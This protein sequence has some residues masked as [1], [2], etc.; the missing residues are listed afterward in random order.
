MPRQASIQLTGATER[1]VEDKAEVA[2]SA[3]IGYREHEIK[4]SS[5]D[6]QTKFEAI[7][8]EYWKRVE[9]EEPVEE[10]NALAGYGEASTKHNPDRDAEL[11][12][13][14][15]QYKADAPGVSDE[16]AWFLGQS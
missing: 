16:M 12:E 15:R 7:L 1:Q 3:I 13:F 6:A 11:A 5:P 9:A 8:S 2:Y 10:Y 14:H 4:F